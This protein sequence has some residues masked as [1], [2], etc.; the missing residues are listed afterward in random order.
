MRNG[1][2]SALDL[3]KKLGYQDIIEILQ[4]RSANSSKVGS[5]IIIIKFC[6]RFLIPVI[7]NRL[8]FTFIYILLYLV[9]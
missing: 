4:T 9:V 8:L 2:E 1:G 6:C 3:A 7:V 5:L